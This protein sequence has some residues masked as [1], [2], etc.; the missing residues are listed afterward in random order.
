MNRPKRRTQTKSRRSKAAER[1]GKSRT[2]TRRQVAS[3]RNRRAATATRATIAQKRAAQAF[4]QQIQDVWDRFGKECQQF[5]E[6]FNGEIGAHQLHVECNPDTV[7]A[8][9]RLGGEVLVQ[10]DREYKH[11]G[12]FI[13]SQCG[14]FGSC[15]VEQPPIGFSVENDRLQWVYGATPMSADDLAVKLMTELV[16]MDTSPKSAASR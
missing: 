1:S 5:A 10:L 15:I 9:F 7:V 2:G 6:G 3:T 13:S 16:Q 11:V 14:D 8:S 12:C 4:E